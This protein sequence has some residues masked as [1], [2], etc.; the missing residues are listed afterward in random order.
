LEAA[1]VPIVS[2]LPG[3]ADS[4]HRRLDYF[5]K[6]NSAL[7][8]A[9][10][11]PDIPTGRFRVDSLVTIERIRQLA[12]VQ[13][14]A[15]LSVRHR[16]LEAS[17][18]RLLG[19]WALGVSGVYVVMGDQTPTSTPKKASYDYVKAT[20]FVKIVRGLKD[21]YVKKRR[22][23]LMGNDSPDFCVGGAL[24]PSREGEV[25]LLR[26][27]LDAGVEFLITQTLFEHES[28]ARI[29]DDCEGAGVRVSV[30]IFVT[31]P[32]AARFSS[33]QHLGRLEGVLIP[34]ATRRSL[35]M[36]DDLERTCL[37]L[38]VRTFTDCAREVR[39]VKLGAYILPLGGSRRASEL[40]SMLR[41]GFDS[42]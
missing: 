10:S 17:V 1:R 40:A 33:I 3:W 8:D 32:V 15:G 16:S 14:L 41:N 30:P 5:I 7:C 34:E 35:M 11:V 29:L 27:K 37:E 12:P 9:I 20:E 13:V 4:D 38:A 2:E 36:S 6:E 22:L 23:R 18:A 28:L 24:L 21:G 26:R 42:T 25:D 31:L 39:R 19:F